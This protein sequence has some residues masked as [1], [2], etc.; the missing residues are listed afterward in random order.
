MRSYSKKITLTENGRGIW[1][2]DPIMGC[3]SG[4][5][6]D[7]KGCF[8]DCYAARNAR[9]YGYD[10]TENV[11]RDFE[12][13]KHLQSVIRKINRLNFPFIR[14]GNSGD[15]SENWGHTLSVLEKLKPVKKQFIIITR[16]W[17]KLTLNQLKRL[18][19]LNVCINT[20]V[21]A[22]DNEVELHQNIQQYEL[23]KKY[24]KS[25]LRSV[26]FDFNTKN[27]KGMDYYLIQNWLFNNYEVLDT[28]FRCSKSNK[29]YKEGI[30]NIKETKFL[31]NKCYVSKRN[32]KTYFGNCKNCLEK[33]GLNM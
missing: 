32:K 27:K 17:N 23:L 14:M 22:I 10:F 5:E 11:L 16:H 31:G 33:C 6:K 24:C 30:I 13:D 8:S 1:T 26:S 2:I 19:K 21:S 9:I 18:S 12:S 29:L 7:K 28:V 3:K 15:P 4:I 25:V 20:S